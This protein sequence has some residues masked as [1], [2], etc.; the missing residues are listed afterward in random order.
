MKNVQDWEHPS[1]QEGR[2]TQIIPLHS[3]VLS[4]RSFK[5]CKQWDGGFCK[6]S[7]LAW[8]SVFHTLQEKGF[9]QTLQSHTGRGQS[10]LWNFPE[11]K[12]T[13]SNPGVGRDQTGA[14]TETVWNPAQDVGRRCRRSECLEL[15]GSHVPCSP[16][17]TF[18]DFSVT[19][20]LLSQLRCHTVE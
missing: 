18:M 10:V 14:Q 3:Q 20:I 2:G 16:Q 11:E 8:T 7:S 6:L 5:L 9:R 15:P 13:P 19:Q 4:C 17:P 1:A 12:T